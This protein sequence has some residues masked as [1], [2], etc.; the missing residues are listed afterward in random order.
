MKSYALALLA[1]V[2]LVAAGISYIALRPVSPRPVPPPPAIK[3]TPTTVANPAVP[4]LVG[5]LA[6][7]PSINTQASTAAAPQKFTVLADPAASLARVEQLTGGFNASDVPELA[8]YLSHPNA[9]VRKAARMGLL[10]LGDPA[11]SPYLHA[12]ANAQPDP[13]E[14]AELRETATFLVQPNLAGTPAPHL[15]PAEAAQRQSEA[16]DQ[17]NFDPLL[18]PST[19][20]E[21]AAQPTPPTP[22]VQP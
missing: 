9:E 10:V 4:P 20:P 12:A 13:A 17:A 11:A 15:T 1:L 2:A 6:P 18:S 16:R 22:Y 5:P 3:S 14:A 19:Q 8:A 21:P 7:I